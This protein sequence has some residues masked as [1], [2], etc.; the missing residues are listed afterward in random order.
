MNTFYEDLETLDKKLGSNR[1]TLYFLKAYHKN[2]AELLSALKLK[3]A[4][5]LLILYD[6]DHKEVYKSYLTN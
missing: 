3:E 4:L 2:I 1:E 6:H 5:E